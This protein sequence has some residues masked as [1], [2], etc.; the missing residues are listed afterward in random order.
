MQ[1]STK[2]IAAALIALALLNTACPSGPKSESD[3]EKAENKLD[4]AINGVNAL[5]KTARELYRQNVINLQERQ[6]A[7]KIVEE[8][9]DALEKVADRVA[10]VDLNNP[11]SV[12]LGKADVENLLK[13]AI[14][15]LNQFGA[16]GSQLQLA[17]AAIVFT[18]N[19][20]IALVK[21]VKEV[22][23]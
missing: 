22:R 2:R 14:E 11:E 12:K 1:R 15:K 4:K 9:N 23:Q 8:A 13:L 5:A 3:I 10:L 18:I 16:G 19:E 6:L 17:A 7:G 21:L 20:T